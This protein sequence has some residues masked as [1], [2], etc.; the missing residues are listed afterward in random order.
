MPYNSLNGFAVFG[1]PKGQ[2]VK[3]FGF[4]NNSSL[5]EKLYGTTLLNQ[6]SLEFGGHVIL[7]LQQVTGNDRVNIV[8]S[9]RHAHSYKDESQRPGGFVGCAISFGGIPTAK[10]GEELIKLDNQAKQ[11]IESETRHFRYPPDKKESW[12]VKPEGVDFRGLSTPWPDGILQPLTSKISYSV[13]TAGDPLNSTVA[14][15]QSFLYNP[16]FNSCSKLLLYNPSQEG[17]IESLEGFNEVTQFQL[18]DLNVFKSKQISEINKLKLDVFKDQRNQLIKDKEKLQIDIQTFNKEID[19]SIKKKDELQR[20]IT[21]LRSEVN[22]LDKTKWINEDNS[23]KTENKAI[24][25]ELEEARKAIESLKSKYFRV[26]KEDVYR[27]LVI[28]AGFV[29]VITLLLLINWALGLHL[30]TKV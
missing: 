16:S 28:A 5:T 18:Q 1:R 8:I 21:I 24:K 15:I 23:L 14:I 25:Q 9:L 10:L 20:K 2:E 3:A 26:L 13:K 27:M 12:P 19:N 4:L 11:L 6:K 7:L 29:L 22:K 30:F 17:N